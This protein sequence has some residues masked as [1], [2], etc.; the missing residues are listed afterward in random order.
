MSVHISS[1]PVPGNSNFEMTNVL[2]LVEICVD[3]ALLLED[4]YGAD[5][6]VILFS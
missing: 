3:I 1:G 6:G 5:F 4:E 2:G